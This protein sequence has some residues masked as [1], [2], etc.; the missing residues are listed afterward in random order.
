MDEAK[1]YLDRALELDPASSMARYEVAIWNSKSGHY[2]EAARNLEQVTRT[3]PDWL[4]PHIELATV[5][6][7]LHRP[8]DGARERDVVTRLTA[9]QQKKGPNIP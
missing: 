7:R 6:Y 9:Q 2:E 1:P 5:Y 4:E 3:D 8:E